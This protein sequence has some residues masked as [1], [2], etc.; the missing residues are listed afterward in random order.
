MNEWMGGR[1]TFLCWATSSLSDLFAE[2]PLLAA[3][4]FLSSIEQPLIW[5]TSGLSCLPTTS[6]PPSASQFFSSR[7]CDNAFSNLLGAPQHALLRGGVANA[8]CR[9]LHTRVAGAS[10]QIDHRSHSKWQ[11]GQLSVFYFC[12]YEIELWIQS[13]AHFARPH[14]PKVPRALATV[15]CSLCRLQLLQIEPRPRGNRDPSSATPGATLPE[16]TQGFAPESVFTR[17]FTRFR[18]ATLP[19][20]LMMGGF[21]MMMWFFH[22]NHDSRP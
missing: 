22:D 2:A 15:L 11:W 3:T 14:L 4:S 6:F 1:A 13:R 21:S 12:L 8:F 16:R 18:T 20:Y 19:N 10:D 7:S 17:E 5:A 9:R